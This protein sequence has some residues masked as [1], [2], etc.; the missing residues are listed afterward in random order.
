MMETNGADATGGTG[1]LYQLNG[2]TNDSNALPTQDFLTGGI[3]RNDQQVTVDTTGQI[4]VGSGSWSIIDGSS[5]NFTSDLGATMLLSGNEIALHWG[6]T[7][8]NDVIEGAFSVPEPGM[9][10]LLA[11]GLLGIGLQLQQKPAGK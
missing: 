10:L 6:F 2:A 8:A 5:I 4:D 3:F 11:P 1:T 9:L 7:C